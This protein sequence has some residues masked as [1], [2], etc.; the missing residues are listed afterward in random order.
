MVKRIVNIKE[1]GRNEILVN[2]VNN[3]IDQCQGKQNR[4]EYIPEWDV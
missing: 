3:K 1:S 2:E 4:L